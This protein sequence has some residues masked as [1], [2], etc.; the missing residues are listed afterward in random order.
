MQKLK[1]MHSQEEHA[2]TTKKSLNQMNELINCVEE[3]YQ[4]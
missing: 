1:R 4:R 2:N 3:G